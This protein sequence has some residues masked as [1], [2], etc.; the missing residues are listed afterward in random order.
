MLAE[1][2][3]SRVEVCIPSLNVANFPKVTVEVTALIFVEPIS[4]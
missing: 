3:T 4:Q 1:A 2:V